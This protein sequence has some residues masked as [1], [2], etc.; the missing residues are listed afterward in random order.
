MLAKSITQ[1][2]RI[3]LRNPY[4]TGCGL[5]GDHNHVRVVDS[6]R[7][8]RLVASE[9]LPQRLD[10]VG[11]GDEPEDLAG[12]GEGRVGEGHPGMAL[13]VAGDGDAAVAYLEDGVAGD[14]G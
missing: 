5:I 12:F 6:A 14:E 13:V 3:R 7:G 9:Q 1:R 10:L 11:A 8:D 4:F 2:Y